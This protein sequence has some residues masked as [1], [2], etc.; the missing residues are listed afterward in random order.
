M[1]YTIPCDDHILFQWDCQDCK[2]VRQKC[3]YDEMKNDKVFCK[4]CCKD[5][6]KYTY[7]KHRNTK[8]HQ[9]SRQLAKARS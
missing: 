7:K 8:I 4:Y 9:V 3:L 2:N 1:S 6:S 5:V